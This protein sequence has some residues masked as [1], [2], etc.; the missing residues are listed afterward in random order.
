MHGSIY[1]LREF[2]GAPTAARFAGLPMDLCPKPSQQL[3]SSFGSWADELAAAFVRL[4][5]RKIT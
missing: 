1:V 5:P 4:E 3:D 2:T